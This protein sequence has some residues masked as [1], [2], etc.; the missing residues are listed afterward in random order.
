MNAD[1]DAQSSK[2]SKQCR[3]E[4][5]PA[6]R[7]LAYYLAHEFLS[8]G[9]LFGRTWSRPV[10]SS[11][12]DQDGTNSSIRGTSPNRPIYTNVSR[13]LKSENVHLPGIVNP[14]QLSHW[15]QL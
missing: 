15:L 4:A 14:T 11:R 8:R 2:D 12:A 13:I 9:T 1:F 3:A 5:E 6:N 10:G 7:I